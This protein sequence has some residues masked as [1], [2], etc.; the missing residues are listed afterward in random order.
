[1]DQKQLLKMLSYI[2]RGTPVAL[3]DAVSIVTDEPKPIIG[4]YVGLTLSKGE[5]IVNASTKDGA[6]GIRLTDLKMISVMI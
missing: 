4:S 5:D 2:P 3:Y 1:M 6:A